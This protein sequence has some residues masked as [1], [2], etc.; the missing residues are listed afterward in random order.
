MDGEDGRLP[1]GDVPADGEWCPWS[2]PMTRLWEVAGALSGSSSRRKKA[3]VPALAVRVIG[4]K[5]NDVIDTEIAP[6][7]AAWA[8]S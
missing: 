5:M 2:G 4:M 8:V 6:S 3:T 1:L 7:G